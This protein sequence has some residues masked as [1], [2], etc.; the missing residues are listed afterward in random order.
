M[1]RSKRNRLLRRRIALQ[2]SLH[3][4]NMG[5]G[6]LSYIA[7]LVV[8]LAV[9]L[10]PIILP[11]LL[12]TMIRSPL[13]NTIGTI[14]NLSD[15][16]LVDK[17]FGKR[18]LIVGG[19]R[20]VGFGTALAVAR[21]GADVTIVGHSLASGQSAVE[22]LQRTVGKGN[23]TFIAGDIGT[24]TT[25]LQLVDKLEEYV[26]KSHEKPYGFDYM[27]VSAAVFPDWTQPQQQEDGIDRCFAVAV[28]GRYILY[29]SMSRF[30]KTSVGEYRVLNVMASG[31]MPIYFLKH[32]L[33]EGK[34]DASNLIESAITM[35]SGNELMLKLIDK[36]PKLSK[37]PGLT[38]ISTSPGFLKS[39]LHR[40]QGWLWDLMEVV[41]YALMGT[42]VE[43]CGIRQ[44]SILAS[45]LLPAKQLSRVT[46]DMR[47]R[48]ADPKLERL[49]ETELP[50]LKKFL[51][52]LIVFEHVEGD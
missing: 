4:F 21:G 29:K 8:L 40:G 36:D 24:V 9:T 39:D 32:D 3:S 2:D 30:M 1:T 17:Y 45:P 22:Q 35:A 37:M 20:G 15:Q 46:P 14:P 50:W 19:T 48:L 27:V 38:L 51:D 42:S 28:V 7:V 41:T 44:A 13:D 26:Q 12:E 11:R 43:E 18:V 23:I 6:R 34:R 52:K 10:K 33:A 16:E 49:V 47:G 5:Y 31:E 25:S